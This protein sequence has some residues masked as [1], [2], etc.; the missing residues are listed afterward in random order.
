ME[1]TINYLMKND[2]NIIKYYQAVKKLWKKILEKSEASNE[3]DLAKILHFEQYQIEGA[4]DDD[5]ELGKELMVLIGIIQFHDYHTGF[6]KS[7]D[8]AMLVYNAIKKS[9]CSVEV[10]SYADKVAS[11]FII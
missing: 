1:N 5:R 7:Y 3:D 8:Q 6:E 9:S 11:F 10:K 4:C 2:S